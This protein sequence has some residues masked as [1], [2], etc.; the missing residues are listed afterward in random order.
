VKKIYILLAVHV[1]LS[2]VLG[3]LFVHLLPSL[4]RASGQAA[5]IVQ[6]AYVAELDGGK[7]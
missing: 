1:A 7:P 2:I 4:L 3:V 5:A 6:K